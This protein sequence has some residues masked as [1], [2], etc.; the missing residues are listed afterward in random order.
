MHPYH[1]TL[2]S[3]SKLLPSWL[4]IPSLEEAVIPGAFRHKDSVVISGSASSFASSCVDIGA[5]AQFFNW[6]VCYT[7]SLVWLHAVWCI[8]L[9]GSVICTIIEEKHLQFWK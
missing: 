2:E 1:I 9:N 4:D 7:H 8:N 6:C 5:L 3:G